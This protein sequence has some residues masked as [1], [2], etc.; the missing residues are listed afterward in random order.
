[1]HQSG[2]RKMERM[3]GM[4]KAVDVEKEKVYK[5]ETSG[6]VIVQ[7]APGGWTVI[8]S[9]GGSDHKDYDDPNR[10][11]EEN[12]QEALNLLE[13]YFPGI[14]GDDLA[15]RNVLD[16]YKE[17]Q[18]P[19]FEELVKRVLYRLSRDLDVMYAFFEEFPS[20]EEFR[21]RLE[22]NLYTSY[23]NEGVLTSGKYNITRTVMKSLGKEEFIKRLEK[24]FNDVF[25]KAYVN[26]RWKSNDLDYLIHS[27]QDAIRYYDMYPAS[28]AV[29]LSFHDKL[30]SSPLD[31]ISGA[32]KSVIHD[33][34]D[35]FEREAEFT[36]EVRIRITL[37]YHKYG[38]SE[39][40]CGDIREALEDEL[41]Q[42][43]KDEVF[44]VLEKK[45]EKIDPNRF[46]ALVESRSTSEHLILPDGTIISDR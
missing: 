45:Y 29:K 20:V 28:T 1:M 18:R 14:A 36:S 46:M 6:K 32:V 37:G 13:S 43:I 24:A 25:D 3:F 21:K 31:V 35:E 26:A 30:G 16:N 33:C 15:C 9:D 39:T 2:G 42:Y 7:A 38:K 34:T 44:P 19:K 11:T 17:K 4:M 40:S 5:S 10:T 8:W 12:F 41:K 23:E 22:E 27:L